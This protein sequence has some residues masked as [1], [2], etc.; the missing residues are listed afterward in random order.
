MP[1]ATSRRRIWASRRRTVVPTVAVGVSPVGVAD[2]AVGASPTVGVYSMPT[3][4]LRP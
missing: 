4:F 1:T 3:V 2:L